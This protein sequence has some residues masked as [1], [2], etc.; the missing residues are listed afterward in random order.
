MSR[1]EKG[2]VPIRR[3]FEQIAW[4]QRG[5]DRLRTQEMKVR[6]AEG[7]DKNLMWI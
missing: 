1:Y 2:L 4:L 3:P 7:R 5:K 6:L